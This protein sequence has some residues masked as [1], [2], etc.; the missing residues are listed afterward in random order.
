M[1]QKQL[2]NVLVKIVGLLVCAQSVGGL[3]SAALT[4]VQLFTDTA[5][6][7]SRHGSFTVWIY[8][9]AHLIE[10]AVGVWLII[11]SRWVTDKLITPADE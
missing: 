1:N 5:H 9:L 2:T 7:F 10:P 8:P 6:G 11:R 3:V 4:L